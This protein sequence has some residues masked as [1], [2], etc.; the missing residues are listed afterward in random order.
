MPLYRVD[1]YAGP[2]SGHRHVNAEDAEDAEAKVR[3][4]VQREMTLPMY[5][6]GYSAKKVVE[7]NNEEQD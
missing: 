1:F 2:Y 7:G 6:D 3:A 5:A 4:I